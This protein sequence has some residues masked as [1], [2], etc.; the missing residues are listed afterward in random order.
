[1]RSAYRKTLDR[2]LTKLVDNLDEE[3]PASEI[4]DA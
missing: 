2:S 4:G 3:N 1:M